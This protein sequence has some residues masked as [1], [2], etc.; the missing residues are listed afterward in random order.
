MEEISLNRIILL[1][2]YE[3]FVKMNFQI[4]AFSQLLMFVGEKLGR[5]FI[6]SLRNLP[7]K[8]LLLLYSV[9][10]NSMIYFFSN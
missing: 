10:C 4:Y 3:P 5:F 9:S 2:I 6:L 1:D 8:Y 7:R